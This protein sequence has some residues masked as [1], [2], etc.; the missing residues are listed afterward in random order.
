MNWL[1][2]ES[3]RNLSHCPILQSEKLRPEEKGIDQGPLESIHLT[4]R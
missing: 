1:A 3:L 2:I 4:G